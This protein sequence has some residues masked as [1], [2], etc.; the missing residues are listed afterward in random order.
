MRVPSLH[1]TARG[2]T[3]FCPSVPDRVNAAP[4]GVHQI[5]TLLKNPD[6]ENFRVYLI[7]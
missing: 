5:L 2:G 7:V 1:S 6:F 3:C 4:G